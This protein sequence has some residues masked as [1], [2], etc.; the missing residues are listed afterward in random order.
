MQVLHP[1][2]RS[3]G[4]HQGGTSYCPVAH[5]RRRRPPVADLETYFVADRSNDNRPPARGRRPA[6]GSPRAAAGTR[7]GAAAQGGRPRSGQGGRA[8]QGSRQGGAAAAGAATRQGRQARGRS[9]RF[10][11]LPSWKV[12]L[13]SFLGLVALGLIGFYVA[14]RLIDIPQPNDFADDQTSIV[15][16]N[17]GKNEMGRF[18]AQ[19]RT[20]VASDQIPQ[21]VK[22]AIVAAEDRTFYENRGVSPVGIARAVWG[23][24]SGD[25]AGGGSTITQQYV[26]NYYLTFDQTYTRKAKEAII[27]LKIDQQQSKDETLTAYL[28]T[29]YFG[30]GA[31]GIQ[32]ASQAYFGKNAA[33]LTVEE[34][35]LLAGIVPNPSGW[36]PAKNPE[37]ATE[38]FE[39]VLDG[40]VL[41][42][43]LSEG[44]R[45]AMV[46]PTTQP[47]K[48]AETYAGPNGY[49]LAMVRSELL[50]NSSVTETDL[51]T[52]GL[53]ITT[54]ISRRRPGRGHPGDE[55]P[56]GVPERGPAGDA[57]RGADL[58]RPGQ[59]RHR[60]ALRRRRLP[61]A[62][63][64]TPPPRTSPRRV[65]PSSRS[66][67]SP[68]S[69]TTSR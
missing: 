13:G 4:R 9:R 42:Q 52:G 46:V 37:K 55:R 56:R 40:M 22:D 24:V 15:Y 14:Y 32:A 7:R 58:D 64:A 20:I 29:I 1:E 6:Q 26:K 35:A 45:D 36:D 66:R 31:Y 21:H 3:A 62:P 51:D 49:L 18:A 17:G 5:A 38:R 28:N 65:R 43:T 68:P 69:R 57:A 63:V 25:Y 67:W 53:R 47:E 12:V 44:Q 41:G 34:G 33:D 50:A 10:R 16:Y 48:T 8:G 39:Y 23:Q 11:W 60:R 61:D 27:A 30:R 2:G 59:R 19:D 54:T